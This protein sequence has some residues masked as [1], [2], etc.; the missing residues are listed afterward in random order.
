PEDAP[1]PKQQREDAKAGGDEAA[2]GTA[3]TLDRRL[4]RLGPGDSDEVLYL[5]DDLSLRR[6]LPEQKRRDGDDDNQPR[7]QR[8]DGVERER[9]PQPRRP[10][11][12]PLVDCLTEQRPDDTPRETGRRR[13]IDAPVQWILLFPAGRL[14]AASPRP[15]SSVTSDSL[16]PAGP[17]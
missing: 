13:S 4:N 7:R 14:A 1:E 3:G 5:I 2:A 12:V 16:A 10:V 8:E 11:L 6:L 15:I 17:R 9:R